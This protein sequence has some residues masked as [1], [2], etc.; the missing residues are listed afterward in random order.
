MNIEVQRALRNAGVLKLKPLPAG[1]ITHLAESVEPE[2][3]KTLIEYLH[4][5][6][7]QARV[8]DQSRK[9]L[10]DSL[11]LVRDKLDGIS[12]VPI[13]NTAEHHR[14][15]GLIGDSI[16]ELQT[17][18]GFALALLDGFDPAGYIDQ[19]GR[20]PDY[21]PGDLDPDPE[22]EEEPP[23]READY[24]STHAVW[25][26]PCRKCDTVAEITWSNLRFSNDHYLVFECVQCGI[27]T[28]L[29]WTQYEQPVARDSITETE[30]TGASA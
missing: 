12:D 28:W 23:T 18:L 22:P 8:L 16:D 4:G 14:V 30:T 10:H 17:S 26:H 9:S 13:N 2:H 20:V 3:R 29:D 1:M 7:A 21:E 25:H 6:D 27:K 24:K 19:T 5:V 11:N 15:V